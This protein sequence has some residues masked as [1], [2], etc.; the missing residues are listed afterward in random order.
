MSI[1]KNKKQ[2]FACSSNND[3]I[4]PSTDNLSKLSVYILLHFMDN[5]KHKR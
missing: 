1:N 5:G 4:L 2:D 3:K